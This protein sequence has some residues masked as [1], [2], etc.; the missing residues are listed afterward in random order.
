MVDAYRH[1]LF[2]KIAGAATSDSVPHRGAVARAAALRDAAKPL[3]DRMIYA[4]S[5]FHFSAMRPSTT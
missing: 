5:T 4:L 3:R 1:A 2:H